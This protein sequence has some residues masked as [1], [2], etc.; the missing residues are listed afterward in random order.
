MDPA[1]AVFFHFVMVLLIKEKDSSIIV[2]AERPITGG[3]KFRLAKYSEI[4]K[5]SSTL[6][7]LSVF[8]TYNTIFFCATTYR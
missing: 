7:F 8:N 2:V 6:R 4:G 3:N 1:S 5:V